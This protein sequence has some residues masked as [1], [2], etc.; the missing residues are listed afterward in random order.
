MAG[1]EIM[2]TGSSTSRI[3]EATK[4]QNLGRYKATLKDIDI[5]FEDPEL[6]KM[7]KGF[8]NNVGAR[9]PYA[10]A[11]RMAAREGRMLNWNLLEKHE[12]LKNLGFD[13]EYKCLFDPFYD[14]PL[15]RGWRKKPFADKGAGTFNACEG[16]PATWIWDFLTGLPYKVGAFHYDDPMQG[17][18]ADCYFLSA[19]ASIVWTSPGLISS[20]DGIVGYWYKK[21][22]SPPTLARKVFGNA[23]T[24]TTQK[25][26]LGTTKEFKYACASRKDEVWMSYYEKAYAVFREW[27]KNNMTPATGVLPDAPDMGI[28]NYGD[29]LEALFELTGKK[30]Y[31]GQDPA[32]QTYWSQLITNRGIW[33]TYQTL[34]DKNNILAS[35]LPS[36]RTINPT[37]AWTFPSGW[38][39]GQELITYKDDIIPAN[40]T[41]SILGI[42]QQDG[43]NYIVLRNPYGPSWCGDPKQNSNLL[44]TGNFAVVD[45]VVINLDANDGIFGI[46][47]S[48]F[49]QYFEGFGW[50][51]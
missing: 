46:L 43:N 8:R 45:R 31:G 32:N 14:G 42:H 11:E 13:K 49:G 25:I 16:D 18:L 19:V 41:F 48:A 17:C 6:L 29:P 33:S 30:Y 20:S 4:R 39:N 23:Q 21:S 22:L 50:V 34:I 35:G 24:G 5:E 47:D 40:H 3:F 44:V 51:K 2:K 37:I 26:R 10:L 15:Y 28:L 27:I 9:N 7:G 12:L 38:D 1:N 36:K